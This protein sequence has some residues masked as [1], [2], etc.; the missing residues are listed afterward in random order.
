MPVP[1]FM[2]FGTYEGQSNE[3]GTP[4]ITLMVRKLI[5]LKVAYDT[6]IWWGLGKAQ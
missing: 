5:T 6:N 4:H 3:N 2:E 1:I